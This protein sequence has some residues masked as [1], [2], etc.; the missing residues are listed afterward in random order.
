MHNNKIP[1]NNELPSAAKLLKSTVAA[2]ILASIILVTAVLPAEYGIDP[3]GVG[4]VLGLTKMGKIKVSL[5]QEAIAEEAVA[6]PLKLEELFEDTSTAS[7]KSETVVEALSAETIK[8]D[9]ITVSLEP[10][11]AR[12]VKVK[13]VKGGKVSYSWKTSNDRA[14]FDVHGDSKKHKINYF[15]YSKG[16]AESDSGVLEAEFD[17]KHGWFWRNRSGKPMTIILE[18]KGEFAEMTQEV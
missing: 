18:V 4:R 2:I 15:N 13:M 3:T 12:E 5:A 8:S 1:S 11:Q 10:D 16:S 17:G 14:N 9:S 7:S 6:E